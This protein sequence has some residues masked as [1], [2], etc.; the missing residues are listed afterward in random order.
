MTTYSI[1]IRESEDAELISASKQIGISPIELIKKRIKIGASETTFERLEKK[2]DG[3]YMLLEIFSSEIGFTGGVLRKEFSK[4][5]ETNRA[6]EE[7]EE[8]LKR[9]VDKVKSRVKIPEYI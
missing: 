8:V 4:R 3:L 5:Y 2:V 6:G 9:C 1:Y 7:L